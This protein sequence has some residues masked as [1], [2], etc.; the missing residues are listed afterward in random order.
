[1]TRE[2]VIRELKM[3]VAEFIEYLSR[4]GY[5]QSTLRT[6]YRAVNEWLDRAEIYGIKNAQVATRASILQHY[7]YLQ[8]RPNQK[9]S[10]GLSDNMIASYMYGIRLFYS[11]LEASGVI[12]E[13]PTSTIHLSNPSNKQKHPDILTE[14]EITEVYHVTINY[15]ERA[16][17]SLLYGCGL[18][19]GEAVKLNTN[20]VHFRTGL[21]YV[22]EG[23]GA[24]R[25]VVPMSER[26]RM[27]IKSYYYEER[28]E[29]KN[30]AALILNNA[31]T[32]MRGKEYGTVVKTLMSRTMI[33]KH[34]TPHRLRHS[35]A[36]HLLS[37]GMDVEKVRDFLGHKHLK[38][39]QR[40]THI[41][42]DEII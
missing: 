36:S 18:R 29:I 4:M 42:P 7:Q 12:T 27:D 14:K 1:M 11:W 41:K 16:V 2:N 33:N 9:R 37:A 17:L 23:K 19:R 25:R 32:R 39:T 21:L 35:I 6:A 31:R 15:K 13:N 3:I 24:K 30:Q 38:T 8:N 20:D 26:V 34:I 10:G 5:S 28:P 22:R 40:Y